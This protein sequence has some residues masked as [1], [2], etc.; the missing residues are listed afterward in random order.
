MNSSYVPLIGGNLALN[1]KLTKV[2]Y[3]LKKEKLALPHV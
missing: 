1:T 2:I 3:I